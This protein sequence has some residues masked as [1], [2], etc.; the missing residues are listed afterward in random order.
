MSPGKNANNFIGY[1]QSIA[2]YKTSHSNQKS[3]RRGNKATFDLNSSLKEKLKAT[4][5]G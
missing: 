1:T 4:S 5:S 2:Q 3:P